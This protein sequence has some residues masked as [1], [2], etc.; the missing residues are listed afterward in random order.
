M[1]EYPQTQYPDPP[2]TPISPA[3]LTPG[4]DDAQFRQFVSASIPG[5]PSPATPSTPTLQYVLAGDP[6]ASTLYTVRW[7]AHSIFAGSRESTAEIPLASSCSRNQTAQWPSQCAHQ[8]VRGDGVVLGV[9][10]VVVLRIDELV[11]GLVVEAFGERPL[12]VGLRA[13]EAMC[14]AHSSRVQC[15]S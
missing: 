14:D 7:R 2:S 4:I 11:D 13:L 3:I 15:S 9:L 12:R 1:T 10:P 5:A 6:L 8:P